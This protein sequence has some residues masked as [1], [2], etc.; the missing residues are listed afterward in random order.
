MKQNR[1][2]GVA[3]HGPLQRATLNSAP[4]ANHERPTANCRTGFTLIETA[5]TVVVVGVAIS[6]TMVAVTSSTRLSAEANDLTTATLLA[7]HLREW[8]SRVPLFDPNTDTAGDYDD[9]ADFADQTFQPPRDGA[10]AVLS[11]PA[12]ADWK[13][14]V[15]FEYVDENYLAGPAQSELTATCMGRF[16]VQV[17]RGQTPLATTAWVVS[18]Q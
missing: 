17:Y 3:A 14:V 15:D 9:L 1:K 5:I 11:D 4:A 18:L 10:G 12:W 6:A 16:T 13:Q 7:Q 8:T 2:L